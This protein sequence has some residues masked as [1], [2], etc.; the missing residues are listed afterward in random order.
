MVGWW[1]ARELRA[2]L[3]RYDDVLAAVWPAFRDGTP[4]PLSTGDELRGVGQLLAAAGR[5]YGA[6][7]NPPET[8]VIVLAVARGHRMNPAA[9]PAALRPLIDPTAPL[10]VDGVNLAAQMA[11]RFFQLVKDESTPHHLR[12]WCVDAALLCGTRCLG[13]SAVDDP[14]RPRMLAFLSDIAALRF[15]ESEDPADEETAI[16]HVRTAYELRTPRDPA[17]EWAA[18]L[19]RLLSQRCARLRDASGMAGVPALV[20][21]ALAELDPDS[22]QWLAHAMTAVGAFITATVHETKNVELLDEALELQREIF[23]HPRFAAHR[24]GM[25]PTFAG[26]LAQRFARRRDLDILHEAVQVYEKLYAAEP[27]RF[28]ADLG[29]HLQYR[30]QMRGDSA[31]RRRA[32]ELMGEG[33]TGPDVSAEAVSSY[34]TAT[35]HEFRET[36]EAEVITRALAVVTPLVSPGG[37]HADDSSAQRGLCTLRLARAERETEPDFGPAEEAARRAVAV[38]DSAIDRARGLSLLATVL[39]H[40]YRFGYDLAVLDE[41]VDH[42]RRAFDTLSGT[43]T[44]REDLMGLRNSLIM[45]L[46]ERH[47][48]TGHLAALREA[49]DVA[50]ELVADLPKFEAE[51]PVVL[52]NLTTLMI[53]YARRTKDRTELVRAQQLVKRALGVLRPDHHGRHHLEGAQGSLLLARIS[54]PSADADVVETAVAH[55]ERALADPPSDVL[56]RAALYGNLAHALRERHRRTRDREDLDIALA[57]AL[58]CVRLM[59]AGHPLRGGALGA[60]SWVLADISEADGGYD[61]IREQA[62]AVNSEL[63]ADPALSPSVRVAASLRL[64]GVAHALGEGERALAAMRDAIDT[65]P[66]VVWRGGDRSDHEQALSGTELGSFAATVALAAGKPHDALELLE[67]GRGVLAAQ[68]LE[69]RT[70]AE[71]LTV[72]HPELGARF[73][74]LRAELERVADDLSAPGADRRHRLARVWQET[75]GEIR[76]RDGFADFLRPP[77]AGQLASAGAHGP[78]V[79]LTVGEEGTGHALL[80]DGTGLKVCPLPGLTHQEARERSELLFQA[81]AAAGR[82]GLARAFAEQFVGDLLEWLWTTVAEPVLDTLGITGPPPPGA[83]PPR[84][85]WCPSGPLTFLPWH[86]AGA[87]PDR[88]VSSYTPSLAALLRAREKAAAGDR[89]PLIVA[90]PDLAG[91]APLPGA[92]RE[93]ELA[94]RAVGGELVRGA[95]ARADA[96]RDALHAH[97][98]VHFA[99]HGVQDPEQPSQGRLLLPGGALSVLDVTRLHLPAAEFAY[100][101][102]C[103][104]AVGGTRLPDEAL[105][106]AGSLQLAGFSQV[107]GTL[108]RVDDDSSAEI[109]AQVY[110]RLAVAGP[111]AP[112][113]AR[114]LHHAVRRLRERHPGQPLSWAAHVHSGA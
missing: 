37:P 88:V 46:A 99:C 4:V 109:A 82:S 77:G 40:R 18:A 26:L 80:L 42:S 98:W 103:E 69:L 105:H 10:D 52:D 5:S 63:A 55:F 60:L 48:R 35:A 11:V 45:V 22:P 93:A 62:L 79:V 65:L 111:G 17:A 8:A 50:E 85:W 89:D 95:G 47:T 19:A 1:S 104:T 84:L 33:L 53:E 87:V 83:E 92:L 68:A 9:T 102:A 31:D 101:S 112:P 66:L 36:G 67:A 2:L 24:E 56:R 41:A 96:V 113:A 44:H 28:A 25:E 34:C 43:D 70:D 107:I 81:V 106:L 97:P 90:V 114:A 94:H 57:A 49:I 38:A 12:R 71:D 73:T 91:Q 21:T 6:G 78:V 76:S 74:Q 86:A 72:A 27:R 30:Y 16:A 108:W 110:G 51:T 64:A 32:L 23:R 61:E 7:E 59:P 15:K 29:R 3:E 75:L 54:L 58:K 100:L 14:R 20:R 13:G 39:V